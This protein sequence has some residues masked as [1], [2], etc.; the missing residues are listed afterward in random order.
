MVN[1]LERKHMITYF[2][3]PTLICPDKTPEVGEQRHV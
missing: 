3:C 2:M 1:I